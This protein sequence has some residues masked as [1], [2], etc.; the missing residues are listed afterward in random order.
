MHGPH[1]RGRLDG[2][3]TTKENRRMKLNE[4]NKGLTVALNM[5]P[6]EETIVDAELARQYFRGQLVN[7][8]TKENKKFRNAGDLLKILSKWQGAKFKELKA[9]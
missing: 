2:S 3:Q 6:F 9:A 7:V 5:F 8:D 4:G 1:Q